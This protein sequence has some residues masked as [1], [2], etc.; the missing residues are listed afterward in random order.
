LDD[1]VSISPPTLLHVVPPLP[2]LERASEAMSRQ[3]LIDRL[4]TTGHLNMPERKSLGQISRGEVFAAV[5]VMLDWNVVFP[6]N[7][8]N[9]ASEGYVY[10]GPQIRRSSDGRY[11]GI[12]QRASVHDLRTVAESTSRWFGGADAAVEW[13]IDTEWGS[14]IDGIPLH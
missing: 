8:A 5:R 9:A 4:V 12:W 11:L 13:Y 14:S 6:P 1:A 3:E 10:E 7:A 2:F